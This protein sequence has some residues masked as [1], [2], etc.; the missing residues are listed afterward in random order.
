MAFFFNGRS[1]ISPTTVSRVDDSAMENQA[2]S[3]GNNLAVL[4]QS[5]GGRPGVVLTFGSPA[6]A[7][8][9]LVSGPALDA[10]RRAFNPSAETGGPAQVSVIRVNP[11]V[12]AGLTLKDSAGNDAIILT[13]TD[14][15]LRANAIRV[16]VEAGSVSGKKITTQFG[17]SYLVGDN[18]GRRAFQV[19]YT[20][21]AVTATMAIS[22]SSVVLSAPAGTT[23]ATIDLTQSA[24]K[25]VQGLVDRINATPGFSA[26]VLDGNGGAPA[27]N[28]LDGIISAQDVK[29]SAY[30]ARADLQ[31]CVDWL[32]GTGETFVNAARATAGSAPPANLALTY[33]SGG[34]DGVTTNNEWAAAFELL[35]T[36]DVQ[37][38]VPASTDPS[39]HAMADAHCQFMST[40]G[41]Q[42]RRAWVGT[43]LG[44][45]DAAAI[46]LSLAIN[47]DRTALVHLGCY[48]YDSD[49]NLT[50]YPPY[51]TAAAIA[52]GFAG[53]DPGETMTNKALS[54]AGLERYVRNPTDT[55]V[56]I[57]GGVT[58]VERTKAGFKVVKAIS[59]WRGNSKF[60]R[61]EV[62]TGTALDFVCRNVREAL[63]VL[64]G[65][66][67]EPLL[68]ARAVNITETVLK[69]LAK[70]R[71]EGAG[72][73]VG[74]EASPAFRGI[75]ASLSGDSTQVVFECSPK[76]PNNYIGVV[77]YA[78]PYSG[79]ATA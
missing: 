51:V 7:A 6:E 44:T 15:G 45:T 23:L 77:V 42:E 8:A 20:G 79:T 63:D 59:T 57:T 62:S 43:P 46:T 66:G 13:S 16:K 69:Q 75:K 32:N 1:Y 21:A 50:L 40:V 60:N 37:W 73:I 27:L 47:S 72:V 9:A 4:G 28:G 11:A 55:D 36:A 24:F 30:V 38:V 56:L 41:R 71:P 29:T 48:G 76:V 5:A 58:A 25:T 70:P 68:L 54:V 31:A 74:D 65:Q 2:L 3:V 61:V 67:G 35:Q 14:Y 18:I 19:Q 12:Q 34:T 33:L 39:I 26:S 10:V 53:L 17:D 49:G 22:N 64:R 52:G 78:K